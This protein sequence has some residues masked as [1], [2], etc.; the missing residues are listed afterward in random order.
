MRLVEWRCVANVH[1]TARAKQT[2]WAGR[3]NAQSRFAASASKPSLHVCSGGIV[4]RSRAIT[5]PRGRPRAGHDNGDDTQRAV[6]VDEMLSGR[7]FRLQAKRV[8]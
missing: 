8:G 4:K 7:F 6:G 3:K 2:A 1:T 5:T